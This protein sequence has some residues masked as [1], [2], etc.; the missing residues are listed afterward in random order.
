M[1]EYDIALK[2]LLQGSARVT[3]RELTGTAIEK[4]LDVELTKVRNPRVD[5]LGETAGGSL[6]HGAMPSWAEERLGTW[7]AAQL[8]DLSEPMLD[9]QSIEDL[10]K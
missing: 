10:L 9:A 8:E 3:M 1:Q 2:L 5:L 6:V 7:S 4:W